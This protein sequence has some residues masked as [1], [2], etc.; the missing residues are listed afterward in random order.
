MVD[1]SNGANHNAQQSHHI[2]S[3]ISAIASSSR[4]CG[5]C[6]HLLIFRKTRSSLES[7]SFSLSPSSSSLCGFKSHCNSIFALSLCTNTLIPFFLDV[8]ETQRRI[9]ETR[10]LLP[11]EREVQRVSLGSLLTSRS[12][13]ERKI[14]N[15]L[16]RRKVANQQ[17]CDSYGNSTFNSYKRYYFI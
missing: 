10:W 7:S 17:K 3:S 12:S 6:H 16:K 4:C 14:E 9:T 11:T 1:I 5:C 15:L 13:A 2:K 8:D